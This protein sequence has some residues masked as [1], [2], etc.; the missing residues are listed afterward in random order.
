LEK[1][2]GAHRVQFTR[3]LRVI[4]VHTL[5]R[6]SEYAA[7][8]SFVT[9][10]WACIMPLFLSLVWQLLFN[11][12]WLASEINRT[13][14]SRLAPQDPQSIRTAQLFASSASSNLSP[15]QWWWHWYVPGVELFVFGGACVIVVAS[16]WEWCGDAIATFEDPT[17]FDAHLEG[18]EDA[19]ALNSDDDDDDDGDDDEE[20]EGAAVDASSTP[21][22][23]AVTDDDDPAP[24]LAVKSSNDASEPPPA[25]REN[26]TV[27]HAPVR[28]TP[29]TASAAKEGPLNVSSRRAQ[30]VR[31]E[32]VAKE[33]APQGM[34][35]NELKQALSTLFDG[36]RPQEVDVDGEPRPAESGILEHFGARGSYIN[37]IAIAFAFGVLFVPTMLFMLGA[38]PFMLGGQSGLAMAGVWDYVMSLLPAAHSVRDTITGVVAVVVQA[39]TGIPLVTLFPTFR[40]QHESTS[41]HQTAPTPGPARFGLWHPGA[42][43]FAAAG[44]YGG[45]GFLTWSLGALALGGV[46]RHSSRLCF[47]SG[48][49][50]KNGAFAAALIRSLVINLSQMVFL[51]SMFGL[52]LCVVT[53]DYWTPQPLSQWRGD[54]RDVMDAAVKMLP[55]HAVAVTPNNSMMVGSMGGVGTRP[56]TSP[57][58]ALPLIKALHV[59][60]QRIV[61]LSH[62]PETIG[63]RDKLMLRALDANLW[64]VSVGGARCS[65]ATS[66]EEWHEA[67]SYDDEVPLTEACGNVDARLVHL[68]VRP[69]RSPD[70]ILWRFRLYAIVAL[71]HNVHLYSDLATWAPMFIAGLF[72]SSLLWHCIYHI[73]RLVHHSWLWW[74]FRDPVE[75]PMIH[76]MIRCRHR[77]VPVYCLRNVLLV[78][79]SDVFVVLPALWLLRQLFP[80]S[81]P[82][83][84]S[85]SSGSSI[86]DAVGANVVV[87]GGRFARF[88]ALLGGNMPF[89]EELLFRRLAMIAGF[90]RDAHEGFMERVGS[91]L[92]VATHLQEGTAP[93]AARDFFFPFRVVV[94]IAMY[95]IV[96]VVCVCAVFI[97]GVAM[98]HWLLQMFP[99]DDTASLSADDDHTNLPS[100]LTIHATLIGWSVILVAAQVYAAAAPHVR[101]AILTLRY[102]LLHANRLRAIWTAI[103]VESVTGGAVVLQHHSIKVALASE[104]QR[105][106]TTLTARVE[107]DGGLPHRYAGG[108]VQ[109]LADHDVVVARV[110]AAKAHLLEVDGMVDDDAAVLLLT[111]V[112]QLVAGMGTPAFTGR[113]T[114]KSLS[115][116]D[117]TKLR[118]ALTDRRVFPLTEQLLSV[119]VYGVVFAFG[120]ALT[121]L[122]VGSTLIRLCLS[123]V[124]RSSTQTISLS[125]SLPTATHGETGTTI[126]VANYFLRQTYSLWW[127]SWFVGALVLV[128][129]F[130]LWRPHFPRCARVLRDYLRV[131]LLQS[132]RLSG[133]GTIVVVVCGTIL[134]MTA[135]ISFFPVT[136]ARWSRTVFAVASGMP[137]PSSPDVTFLVD[138]Y[139]E[140]S[141][142]EIFLV[143]F[144]MLEWTLVIAWN[145]VIVLI[146]DH[147]LPFLPS[148][149]EWITRRRHS[150]AAAEVQDPPSVSDPP[151]AAAVRHPVSLG[152][153]AEQLHLRNAEVHEEDDF[154]PESPAADIVDMAT[155]P[156][157]APAV[158]ADH[159]PRGYGVLQR[160]RAYVERYADQYCRESY[161]ALYLKDIEVCNHTARPHR[162]LDDE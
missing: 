12:H 120:C 117:A 144:G 76:Q 13:L 8:A 40:G 51:P 78:V 36:G 19:V 6:C 60:H 122:L 75:T 143:H 142:A 125:G 102:R 115:L 38:S 124:V 14:L 139:P 7:R 73:R 85:W 93:P 161:D 9:I 88:M 113:A 154:E 21:T 62:H 147:H 150:P 70:Q 103:V 65:I 109:W 56:T 37:A 20:A 66:H 72:T 101:H 11:T 148:N 140:P 23:L 80:T 108:V 152:A 27:Y 39:M 91:D 4:L 94:F 63:Y 135:N 132:G 81:L 159:A 58:P 105:D 137:S 116:N 106:V 98:N 127:I 96:S 151:P 82:L 57:A 111:D 67:A 97:P 54:A 95:L 64:D 1:G 141:D 45:L 138:G 25:P 10:V 149:R 87:F 134:W 34:S 121:P 41:L 71:L 50:R 53:A 52:I 86:I 126:S 90:L 49:A 129:L 28:G 99:A 162:T 22:P 16:F 84:F 153:L 83:L 43:V 110:S 104:D 114:T 74:L 55:T 89:E 69:S 136:V 46:L 157:P 48:S 18:G 77:M 30:E 61:H 44:S 68:L 5:R 128:A 26:D 24:S 47:R 59:V 29:A 123:G 118:R 17:N 31:A 160:L 107:A 33:L 145:V 3:T 158:V 156:T 100:A 119:F 15:A 155:P 112:L 133:V 35:P 92:R 131:G 42:V 146:G 130:V 79:L 32:E 2:E